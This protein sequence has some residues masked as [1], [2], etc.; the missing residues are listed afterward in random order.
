MFWDVTPCSLIHRTK[1]S[2]KIELPWRWQQFPLSTW[3]LLTTPNSAT[4]QKLMLLPQQMVM[5]TT[6]AMKKLKPEIQNIDVMKL[7]SSCV[8][9]ELGGGRGRNV[10]GISFACFPLLG[11]WASLFSVRST[12]W[13]EE[14]CKS[15]AFLNSRHAQSSSQDKIKGTSKRPLRMYK[16]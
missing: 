4:T 14:R 13:N 10:C 5:Y 16:R 1:P 9:G 8:F 2:H 12:S 3:H 15:T 7:I 11:I 6:W